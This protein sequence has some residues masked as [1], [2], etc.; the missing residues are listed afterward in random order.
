MR[1][2]FDL[3]RHGTALE[4]A[5]A[6][7]FANVHATWEETQECWRQTVLFLQHKVAAME[8]F[9]DQE[10]D[11]YAEWVAYT[12]L[13]KIAKDGFCGAPRKPLRF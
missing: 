6:Q 3:R 12:H 7:E 8:E 13:W 5:M 1:T 9:D 11:E 2:I 10:K 4:Q